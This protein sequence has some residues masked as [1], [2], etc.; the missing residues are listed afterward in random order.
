MPNLCLFFLH[1][2]GCRVIETYVISLKSIKNVCD[3]SFHQSAETGSRL[4]IINYVRKV[5]GLGRDRNEFVAV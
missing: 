3:Q 2:T 5:L 4:I 1:F